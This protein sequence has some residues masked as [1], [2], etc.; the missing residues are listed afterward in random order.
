MRLI[1][2]VGR[3][4]KAVT[5]SAKKREN[6]AENNTCPRERRKVKKEK[7]GEK[8]RHK[9][10]V[11]KIRKVSSGEKKVKKCITYQTSREEQ[12]QKSRKVKSNK[13]SV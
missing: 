10:E 12:K 13:L 6:Q 3:A 5:A 2:S 7:V 11:K 1:I 4:R 8:E 9:K